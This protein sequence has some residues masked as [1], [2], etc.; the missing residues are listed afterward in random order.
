MVLFV[1]CNDIIKNLNHNFFDKIFTQCKY[2]ILNDLFKFQ[3]NIPTNAR[4]T[5]V[6]SLENL[7]TF[8]LQQPCWWAKEYPQAPGGTP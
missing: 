1:V 5:A 3:V 2:H 4:V 7:S 8:L 6:Q